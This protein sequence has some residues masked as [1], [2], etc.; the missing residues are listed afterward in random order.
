MDASI[1]FH[2]KIQYVERLLHKHEYTDSAT[3]CILIIEQALRHIAQVYGERIDDNTRHQVQ[4]AVQKR[5]R[6]SGDVDR[7]TMGQLAHVFRET[8]FFEAVTR[9]LGKD[10]SSLEIVDLEKLTV[11][12]NKFAHHDYL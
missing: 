3:R 8:H 7:L 9:F 12:H 6:Q 10:I 4:N 1:N 5:S 2:E 11:L